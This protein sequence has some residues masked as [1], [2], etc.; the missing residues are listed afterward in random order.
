MGRR[1]KYSSDFKA[2]VAIE[3][4][5]EER[6][7][8]EIASEYGIHPQMVRAWKRAFLKNAPRVFEDHDETKRLKKD[9]E[10]AYRKIGELEVERDFLQ[11]VLRRA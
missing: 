8:G 3:A 10:K 9:L 2:K 5:R 11:D 4:I 7:I 1:R 6:T